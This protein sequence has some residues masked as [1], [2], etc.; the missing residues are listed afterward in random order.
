MLINQIQFVSVLL[1]VITCFV[2]SNR[3]T[4]WR[5]VAG[6]Y[7]CF[8]SRSTPNGWD[9]AKHLNCSAWKSDSILAASAIEQPQTTNISL[10]C[11]ELP[12]IGSCDFG[13]IGLLQFSCRAVQR[14]ASPQQTVAQNAANPTTRWLHFSVLAKISIWP[15]QNGKA[16]Y[17]T[18]W[19]T[20]LAI[21]ASI[22]IQFA[23]DRK[24][25]VTSYPARPRLQC[26]SVWIYVRNWVILHRSNRCWVIRPA[27]FVTDDDCNRRKSWQ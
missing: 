4:R 15:F 13:E 3:L 23:S 19:E 24:Q 8:S 2:D 18:A 22:L 20:I 14:F 16:T 11:W 12:K 10:V 6:L 7:H 5:F 21:K 1:I 9:Q 17:D 27:H 25:L 26:M